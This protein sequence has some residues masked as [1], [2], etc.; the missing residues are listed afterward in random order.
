MPTREQCSA[1]TRSAAAWLDAVRVQE[2]RGEFLTAF[3]LAQRGLAEY[4]DDVGLK[5]RAVLALARAGATDE[6]SRRF[7]E[8]G[9]GGIPE[10]DVAALQARIAKDLAL[11][12]QGEER[13]RLAVRAA[14]RY[15]AVFSRTGGYYPAVNA[16]TLWL[17]AGDPERSRELAT[18][19]LGLL[20]GADSYYVAATEAEARLLLGEQAAATAALER[21]AALHDRDYAAVAGTRRQLRMICDYLGLD[22]SPL[23]LL[24]GPGVV[25]F[26][27]HRIGEREGRIPPEAEAFVAARVAEVVSASAPGFAY[28]SLASGADIIWAEALLRKGCELHVVLP[29]AR[30][31]FITSSVAPSGAGW[32]GRFDRCLAAAA[33]VRYATEDAFLGD[34]VL[35]RYASEYAMGLAVLRAGYLD[36]E[37]RQLAVWDGNPARAAAGTATD[38]ATWRRG[39]RAVTAVSP[40]ADAPAGTDSAY[41]ADGAGV[42]TRAAR[43]ERTVR[44][45]VFGDFQGFSKLTDEQ[46]PVFARRVLGAVAEVLSSHREHIAQRNT[47]GDAVYVVLNDAAAA[48]EFALD[49]QASIAAIDLEAEGLPEHLALRL[50][51]H[52]GP[53][54]PTR[55]PVLDEKVFMGSHVSRTARIEPVTPPGAVYVTEPF[56]AA[57]VLDGRSAFACDYVGHMDAAKGYGRLRMYRLR[58]G[59]AP[60][61][62]PAGVSASSAA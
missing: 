35:F 38:V 6:A 56:A 10:E 19:V 44:A 51:C 30:E 23:S 5:H 26:C 60:A 15:G 13:R 47:W 24:A 27:G 17:V 53:V 11:R 41:A 33:T 39:G 28:G 4:P 54:F 18:A 48:A 50:G 49:V 42:S 43:A 1:E 2:R 21:A 40:S 52:L 14:E 16:A 62:A 37:V 9:M 46:L 57:L 29:L 34:D 31:E 8:Y 12:A 20:D 7:D 25:H 59:R 3:D 22:F 61:G 45:I 32:V 55:D 58:Y 36:A